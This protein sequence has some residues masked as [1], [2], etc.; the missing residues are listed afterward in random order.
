MSGR[1]KPTEIPLESFFEAYRLY[2]QGLALIFKA[3]DLITPACFSYRPRWKLWRSYIKLQYGIY[4]FWENGPEH[5][6]MARIDWHEFDK[7]SKEIQVPGVILVDDK[8]RGS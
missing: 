7:I 6:K 8:P 3:V 5:L 4:E 2:R 1:R